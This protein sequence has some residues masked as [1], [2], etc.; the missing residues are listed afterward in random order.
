MGSVKFDHPDPSILT[1]LTA[2][3]DDHGRA[4]CDFVVF[5]GRWDVLEH[6]FRPPFAHRNAASEVNGVVRS[7]NPSNGYDP[8]CTFVTPLLAA[9]GVSTAT[10]DAVL[11]MSEEAAEGPKRL[12]DESL[13]IMFESALPFRLTTWA[14]NTPTLDPSFVRL[15][16]GMRSRFDPTRR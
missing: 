7:P 4:I 1:V 3:L 12:P 2:P 16:D 14:K 11:G 6:S 9:H 8:G 15:F 10:Y 13:W 5:P